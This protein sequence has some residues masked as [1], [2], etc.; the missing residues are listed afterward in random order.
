MQWWGALSSGTSM[1]C[2]MRWAVC[3]D[4]L[5]GKGP[6]RRLQKRL[7]GRLEEVAKA[8]G[9]GYYRLQMPLRLALRV[10]ETVAGRRL[11]ALEGAGVPP[12][13]P[14]HPCVC[15][16]CVVCELSR[17]TGSPGS[18]ADP[19]KVLPVQPFVSY[20]LTSG[21]PV[22]RNFIGGDRLGLW[23]M[24]GPKKGVMGCFPSHAGLRVSI[25]LPPRGDFGP[26]TTATR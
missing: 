11:G 17:P 14:M 24:N 18:R 19:P 21:E 9:G 5:E 22:H 3:R 7:D 13:V 2:R 25:N 1:A 6:Q 15:R 16:R 20:S 12:P 10:R 8:V 23:Y 4:A 26:Y